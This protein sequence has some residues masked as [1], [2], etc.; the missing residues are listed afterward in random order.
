M[1]AAAARGRGIGTE[2]VRRVQAGAKAAGC[3]YLHV[4]FEDHLSG[5]YYDACGFTPAKAG[6]ITLA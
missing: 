1:V 6:L 5:F 4:D 3:E 2:L